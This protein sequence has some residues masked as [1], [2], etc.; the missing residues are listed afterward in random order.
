M[1]LRPGR[2]HPV[3]EGFPVHARDGWLIPLE[4]PGIGDVSFVDTLKPERARIHAGTLP[5]IYP[6]L[7]PPSEIRSASAHLYNCVGMVFAS[8]RVSIAIDEV[9]NILRHD[10][11]RQIP[12]EI[13]MT[14]DVV[15]YKNSA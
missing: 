11:Y 9:E 5:E 8:R 3:N 4:R 14:G 6:S 2:S 1:I 13:V 15:L 12:R 10:G 7:F